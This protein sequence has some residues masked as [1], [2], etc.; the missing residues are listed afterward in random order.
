M[1]D[2]APDACPR[3]GSDD[4]NRTDPAYYRRWGKECTFPYHDG[5]DLD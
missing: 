3:C 5:A 4:P 2:T 1:S